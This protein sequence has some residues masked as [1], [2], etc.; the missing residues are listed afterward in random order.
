M[1]KNPAD[2]KKLL[3]IGATCA[4]SMNTFAD[5]TTGSVIYGDD[6]RIDTHSVSTE[7][8]ELAS[9]TAGM[10][11][12][13]KIVA[14]GDQYMLPPY[15]ISHDMGL[16]KDEKFS[17]QPSAVVCSGFLVG[18]DLLVTAGHCITEQSDCDGVSWVFDYKEEKKTGKTNIVIP[19]KNVYKCAQV[20]EAKLESKDGNKIDYSLVKLDRPVTGKTPLIFRTD[21]KIADKTE[22]LV[23]GHPTGL[24]QKVSA[25]AEVKINTNTNFFQSNLDTFGGNSGSA[26]FDAKTGAVEGILVRGAQDY[27]YDDEDKCVRVH[28]TT[29]EI[30]D[31]KKYGESVSRITDIKTLKFGKRFL[32]AAEKG[33]VAQLEVFSKLVNEKGIYDNNF[34]TA[35]HKAAQSNK[36]A[37]VAFLA[38]AKVDLDAVNADGD[39]ALHIAAKNDNKEAAVALIQ[40]GADFSLENK[41]GKTAVKSAKLF[42]KTR[43]AIKKAIKAKK[44]QYATIAAK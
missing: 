21:G 26:V 9:A 2:L 11:S 12:N 30:T 20:I 29:D 42:S 39:S 10:I 37:V 32:E 1:L 5:P 24:P 16:C 15:T 4:I 23:I 6:N 35:L 34:N 7:Q 31:Y 14:M 28:Q 27:E 13:N 8:Q 38:D 43:K 25:G 22:I 33:N 3:L 41:K 40:A 44:Q 19:K 18:P 17:E 36:T